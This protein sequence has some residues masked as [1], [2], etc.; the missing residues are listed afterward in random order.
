MGKLSIVP[1]KRIEHSILLIRGEKVMLDS[2]LAELYGVSTGALN[3]AV[4]RNA[5]RFPEDF[6]FRLT[7]EESECLI[8]QIVISKIGRG[9]R[10]KLQNRILME[11]HPNR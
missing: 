8:S 3:Q 10:R 6:M 7:N 4:K 11:I 9:G 5:K 2:I 1:A